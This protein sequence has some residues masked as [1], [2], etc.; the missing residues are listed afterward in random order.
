[1]AAACGQWSWYQWS[2]QPQALAIARTPHDKR[3]CRMDAITSAANGISAVI[4]Q[5]Y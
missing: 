2:E 1:M 5:R 4:L 3:Q